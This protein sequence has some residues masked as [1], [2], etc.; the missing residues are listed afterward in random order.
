MDKMK[1][2]AW[3]H[4]HFRKD[5]GRPKVGYHSESDAERALREHGDDMMR[6]YKCSLCGRYHVGHMSLRSRLIYAERENVALREEVERLTAEAN[7]SISDLNAKYEKELERNRSLAAE[8][9]RIRQENYKEDL[10][11]RYKDLAKERKEIADRRAKYVSE[12]VYKTNRLEERIRQL[13]EIIN[14]G[15]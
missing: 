5:D 9:E 3:L 11:K 1:G 15:Y 2:E 4:E 6:V 12:L 14:N 13:E 8:N 7:G 10:V